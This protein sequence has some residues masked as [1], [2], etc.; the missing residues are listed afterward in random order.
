MKIAYIGAGD[1]LAEALAQRMGQEGND[2]YLLSDKALPRR[3]G[4]IIRHR[5]YRSP[6][7]GK[8]FEKLLRSIA[9]DCVIFSGNHYISSTCEEESEED[10][11]LLARS[12]RVSAAFL[13]IKFILLSSIDV[14]GS[15]EGRADE[16]AECAAAGERGIRFIREEQLLDIY[17][18]RHGMD[19]VILRASQLYSDRP[20]EDQG[21]FLSRIFLAAIQGKSPMSASV[22][23]PLHVSD[24][25][26]AV[27]R[28]IDAGSQP[29]Y[30]VCGSAE[31]SA[32]RLCRLISQQEKLPEKEVLWE[33]PG[34]VILADS[35]RIRQQ[36]EWNNFR[37]LE[38][39]MQKGEITY[40]RVPSKDK[41]RKKRIVPAG[42]RQLVENL[43]LFAVFFAL[44][45]LFGSHSLLSQWRRF[46]PAPPICLVRIRALWS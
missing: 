23:Q 29:V 44:S 5:F 6:R 21:D 45:S 40:E 34:C 31:I 1:V 3:Q 10:V 35:S 41:S 20:G 28:V 26:D 33:E 14:Y 16:S 37:D 27:K 13:H 17:R 7:N 39:Q 32:E 15:T 25:V 30:N 22:F 43:L 4:D 18:K 42:I 8:S 9:P 36:L 38:E 2:V 24:F 12:L 46:W 11:A 19:A